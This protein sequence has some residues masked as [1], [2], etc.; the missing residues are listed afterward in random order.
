M[1]RPGP[2]Q[3]T[4]PW[5]RALG[6]LVVAAG[7]YAW[8]VEPYAIEVTRRTLHAPL[9]RPLKIAHLTDLHTR[10]LGRR[11]RKMLA[12]LDSEKPDAIV[13][14]GDSVID[15]D[16][17]GPRPGLPE[18]PSYARIAPVLRSLHAPLG[19]W[20]VRGNW[21][22]IRHM[23]GE[24][25]FYLRNGVRLLSN[26][27]AE[28]RAGVWVAG[29]DDARPNVSLAS[30]GIPPGAFVIGLFHSPANFDL[31]AGKWPLALAGH[32]H[33]GQVRIPMVKPFWL[34]RGSGRYVAGWYESLGSRLYVSRGIGTS[35]LPIRFLCRPELAILTIEPS[36]KG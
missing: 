16:L 25:A 33:G 1:H 3:R 10:G 29:L 6:I 7:A 20:T 23:P 31:V 30:E 21:E 19:V 2:H 28:L 12:I 26:E 27:A 36:S 13:I 34:P 8:G 18:D 14:T 24:R 9:D 32:T 17:F 4:F 22:V 15:G 35:T 5:R 11:E